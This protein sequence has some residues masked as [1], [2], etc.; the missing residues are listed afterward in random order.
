MKFCFDLDG[1]IVNFY[2]VENWLNYLL[3]E[4]TTPY[5]IAKPLVNLRR[6]ARLLNKVQSKGNQIGII[7]WG[8]KDA[9]PEFDEAVE[10]AK[11]NWL[12]KHMPSVQWDFVHIVHYGTNKWET[13][14]RT[15]VLFDDEER[16]RVLW[17][18]GNGFTP[19]QMFDILTA[20]AQ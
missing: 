2:G 18:N 19:E 7:S 17:A 8:S 20:W 10:Q 12:M 13:C 5:T 15:G 3:M 1:T 11:R 9:S 6:L 14:G 16:N 4:D